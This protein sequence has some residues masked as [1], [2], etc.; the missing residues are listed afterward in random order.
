VTPVTSREAIVEPRNIL[1]V[2]NTVIALS[3]CRSSVENISGVNYDFQP[4]IPAA[5]A[6]QSSDLRP[7]LR[8]HYV[9]SQWPQMLYKRQFR[10]RDAIDESVPHP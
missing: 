8:G 2:G 10:S 4:L 1:F 3:R 7:I 9:F 5:G 6:K